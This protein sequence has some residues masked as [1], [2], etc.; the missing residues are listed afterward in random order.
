MVDTIAS[1]ALWILIGPIALED[2]PHALELEID[3]WKEFWYVLLFITD[4]VPQETE[5][6]IWFNDAGGGW[7][8]V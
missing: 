7:L 1:G 4:V 3:T 2:E 6:N 5:L 8:N